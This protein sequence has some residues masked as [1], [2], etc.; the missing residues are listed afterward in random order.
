MSVQQRLQSLWYRD[1][2][3][4]WWLRALVPVYRLLNRLD[5]WRQSRASRHSG[6]PVIVIGNLTV[7]GTGKTPL[8]LWCAQSL[9]QR[10]LKPAVVSRGY[11][12]SAAQ[13]DQP[14]VLD[15]DSRPDQVG[16][17]PCL[18]R[19]RLDI[20]VCVGRD[21]QR[22]VE[23]VARRDDVD[24]ILSDDGLQHLRMRRD[25]SI[26]IFD[27]TRGVGNGALLP[28]GPLRRPLSDLADVDLVVCHG[29]AQPTL[30]RRLS[31]QL[32]NP[33]HT[34]NL[35]PAAAESLSGQQAPR[36]LSRFSTTAEPDSSAHSESI[37]AIA[38]I[39][40]PERFF[41]MLD[42]HGIDC[43]TTALDDHQVLTTDLLARWSGQC[44]LMTE[45]DAVK[46]RAL[47]LASV[48]IGNWWSVPVTARLDETFESLWHNAV[49]QLL[50]SPS[51]DP[52]A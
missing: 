6:T 42:A 37:H 27:G 52:G 38:G 18:I 40:N 13:S 15:R 22:C 41:A 2:P 25:L 46:C 32:S 28:A 49:S 43:Q 1:G 33:W 21:R 30:A 51:S 10:G 16:D 34:M 17:E 14:V 7:G 3:P 26:V 19:N 35:E 8:V 5:R 9:M 39:G 48:D 24:V 50:A 11:G 4:V 23:L 36:P 31:E 20:V 45:K 29:T 47:N 12:A 44:L